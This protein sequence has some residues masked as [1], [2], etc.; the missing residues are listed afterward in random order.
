MHVARWGH[1]DGPVGKVL[2]VWLSK[3][4]GLDVS[5]GR[6]SRGEDSVSQG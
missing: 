6:G 5:L 3:L 1:Q 4:E 2:A